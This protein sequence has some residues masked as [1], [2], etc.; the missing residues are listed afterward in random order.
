MKREYTVTVLST[1]QKKQ[2]QRWPVRPSKRAKYIARRPSRGIR[3]WDLGSVLSGDT[4]IDLPYLDPHAGDTIL[5]TTSAAPP[6]GLFDSLSSS[7]YDNI[8]TQIFAYG[9]PDW[10]STFFQID[11]T[12]QYYETARI[13]YKG[14]IYTLDD[15]TV[16][17]GQR[18]LPNG[19]ATDNSFI[20][21]I[22]SGRFFTDLDVSA[23]KITTVFDYSASSASFTPSKNMDVFLV[24]NLMRG[25]L[26]ASHD[27]V[28]PIADYTLDALDYLRFIYPRGVFR[29][30]GLD[31]YGYDLTFNAFSWSNGDDVSVYTP[32]YNVTSY[33]KTNFSYRALRGVHDTFLGDTITALDPA[34]YADA[35]DFPA[36]PSLP[37]YPTG[38]GTLLADFVSED[39]ISGALLAVILK[40]G[41]Y[42]YC[43]Q[44]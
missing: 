34:N 4:Y 40:G 16:W 20:V 18:L 32:V 44:N 37:N 15:P 31:I 25:F 35:S 1:P 8:T 27:Y 33:W 38:G 23:V 26:E 12:Y 30:S 21:S 29:D 17:N 3:F 5:H 24:P 7:H 2:G 22:G 9:L 43:W 13:T 39:P 41:V 14:T 10:K 28:L 36:P 11:D 42:Y 19:A 6:L